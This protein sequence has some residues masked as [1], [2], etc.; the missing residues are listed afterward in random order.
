MGS[1][2]FGGLFGLINFLGF[3]QWISRVAEW[4]VLVMPR[5]Y[6]LRESVAERHTVDCR[7]VDM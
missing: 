5:L 3:I 2:Y 7:I 6:F 1:L 4:N